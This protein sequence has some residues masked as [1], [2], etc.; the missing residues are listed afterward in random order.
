MAK[1]SYF[2]VSAPDDLE[3][4][5]ILKE[6]AQAIED[7]ETDKAS[8]L[9]NEYAGV[10]TDI[11]RAKDIVEKNTVWKLVKRLSGWKVVH[12]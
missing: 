8:D 3:D 10:V 11:F 4:R 1:R 6:L 12:K 7:Q 5:D 2:S 9:V